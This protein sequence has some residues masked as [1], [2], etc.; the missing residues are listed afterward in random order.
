MECRVYAFISEIAHLPFIPQFSTSLSPISE[1][2]NQT[3]ILSCH[4]KSHTKERIEALPKSTHRKELKLQIQ[5][6]S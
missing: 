1:L 6:A 4:I 5:P 2:R 3:Y